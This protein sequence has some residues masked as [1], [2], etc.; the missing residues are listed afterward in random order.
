MYAEKAMRAWAAGLTRLHLPLFPLA[1][2]L[3]LTDK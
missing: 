3:A 1:P 2:R